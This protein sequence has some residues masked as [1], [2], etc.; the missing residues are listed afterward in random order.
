MGRSTMLAD[1]SL[2]LDEC[3]ARQNVRYSMLNRHRPCKNRFRLTFA[4]DIVF[5]TTNYDG[6]T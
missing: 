2:S 4:S 3:G 5:D 1:V 6:R